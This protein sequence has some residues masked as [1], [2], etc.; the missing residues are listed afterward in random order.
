MKVGDSIRD[1][2]IE[3][4][5]TITP[6][7]NE[8][9]RNI[10]MYKK[11]NTDV[12]KRELDYIEN[13]QIK[14]SENKNIYQEIVYILY[15][16]KDIKNTITK[17]SN[18]QI[19][20]EIELFEIK[21]FALNTMILVDYYNH[22]DIEIDY[23][24][25]MSV[26]KIIKI[27]DPDDSK[28]NTFQ[29][30]SSYSDELALIRSQKSNIEKQIFLE[31]EHEIIE[32]LKSERL[33]V[34]VKEENICFEIRKNISLSLNYC[35]ENIYTNIKS[36]GKLDLLIAKTELANRYGAIK[37]RINK[38]NNIVL[39]D[40]VNPRVEA[41]LQK[42][43]KKY[44]PISIELTKKVSIITG[45]NM[46]GKSVS[47]NTIAL[48]LYLFQCG[49]YVFAKE[50][51][52]CV[53]DFIYLI[54]DD[55]QDVSKGL[56]TFGAEIIKLK[57]ITQVIKKQDG[58]IALDEFARGTNPI[59]GKIL[60]KSLCT[61]LKRYNSISLI[62]TH[63]DDIIDQ[64]IDH[65]QVVGLKNVDFDTIKRQFELE[66]SHKNYDNTYIDILQGKMDYNLEKVGE[67]PEVPKDAINIC[68]LLGL[69]EDLLEIAR[70]IK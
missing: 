50:A 44:M 64:E 49:F 53:L 22:L 38:K 65:Y 55:M 21:N 3:E 52:L 9:K 20:D 41:L 6:Y 5:N 37:P 58:F 56:S 48:N 15:K 43:N 61:Y 70:N 40:V 10:K 51:N 30:Y 34:V 63:Y 31:T 14:F 46:G 12:L 23:I 68:K 18:N 16:I 7:G 35:L 60:L 13:L 47:L 1:F 45:A 25:F 42:H 67:K 54:S 26:D 24:K 4:V 57:E 32:K 2:I 62:C 19:L 59:E 8:E 28:L 69:D 17:L 29:I 36:I 11:S 33:D 39:K 66:I 27:L